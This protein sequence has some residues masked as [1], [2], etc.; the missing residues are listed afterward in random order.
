MTLNAFDFI[1]RAS[2]YDVINLQSKFK[3]NDVY[4][5]NVEMV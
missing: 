4:Y 5:P 3:I 1:N 2:M